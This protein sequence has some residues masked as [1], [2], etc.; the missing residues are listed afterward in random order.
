MMRKHRPGF[1]PQP[2][3]CQTRYF[4]FTWGPPNLERALATKDPRH[5]TRAPRRSKLNWTVDENLLEAIRRPG[6]ECAVL[7]QYDAAS[8]TYTSWYRLPDPV[9]AAAMV[10]CV[11]DPGV[12]LLYDAK[13]PRQCARFRVDP[14][15]VPKKL[16]RT[17]V[18][19]VVE[20]KRRS[21]HGPRA[22][23]LG[24]TFK[25][26]SVSTV[27]DAAF[28]AKLRRVDI[29]DD[30]IGRLNHTFSVG[31]FKFAASSPLW[32][33]VRGKHPVCLHFL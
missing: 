6:V 19:K 17:R 29:P 14:K 12:R 33:A 13:G 24:P 3:A 10:G 5:V 7:R 25:T 23:A 20:V 22:C 1:F 9:P 26:K 27:P 16:R 28:E 11:T 32:D 4:R 18:V 2:P 30:V 15:G 21:S 8:R 31:G